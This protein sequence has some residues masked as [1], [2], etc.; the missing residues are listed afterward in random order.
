MENK[1]VH[2]RYVN[3]NILKPWQSFSSLR[4]WLCVLSNSQHLPTIR[5]LKLYSVLAKQYRTILM[6]LEKQ[7]SSQWFI[8]YHLD[9]YLDGTSHKGTQLSF[10]RR[11]LSLANHVWIS[12]TPRTPPPLVSLPR[13]GRNTEQVSGRA[14]QK[15]GKMTLKLPP[16]LCNVARVWPDIIASNSSWLH[17]PSSNPLKYEIEMNLICGK[18]QNSSH[19]TSNGTFH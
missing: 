11:D 1:S 2:H 6:A 12:R 10:L 19:L 7:N 16:P 4:V 14:V 13:Q 15:V 5:A 17:D 18:G 9:I 8:I 3:T